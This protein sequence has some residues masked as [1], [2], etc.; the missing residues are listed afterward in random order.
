MKAAPMNLSAHPA[1]VPTQFQQE[2]GLVIAAKDVLEQGLGLL[3]HIE[4]KYSA[5]A[6]SP[7]NASIGQH[8][9]HVLEHFQCLLQGAASGEVNYDSRQRNP[10]IETETAYA[11]AATREVLQQIE[12]W[13]DVTLQQRCTTVSTVAYHSDAPS[14][15]SSNLARELAYCIGHAI[16][17]Y[18]II[19]LLCSHLGV[20]I[21]AEFGYAPSTLKFQSTMTVD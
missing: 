19:R 9:R 11:G 10:R 15:I 14:T 2:P 1:T 8:Y 6:A 4:G 18:A 21:P 7:F 12:N 5:V 13:T 16:H 20:Q 17:H 3:G